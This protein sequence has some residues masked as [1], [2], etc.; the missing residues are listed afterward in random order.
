[1]GERLISDQRSNHIICAGCEKPLGR[2]VL[3]HPRGM[4][5]LERG[6]QTVR[7]CSDGRV[8][9]PRWPKKRSTC[10]R[11][12]VKKFRGHL[13]DLGPFR[14]ADIKLMLSSLEAGLALAEKHR[15]TGK[16]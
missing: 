1:M 11:A 16:A 15:A 3:T 12:L 10:V 2:D 8:T 6:L 9:D 5:V 13:G 7:V 4:P 14:G